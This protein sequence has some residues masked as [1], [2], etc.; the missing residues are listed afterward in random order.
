[1]Q[2]MKLIVGSAQISDDD[3]SKRIHAYLNELRA[4]YLRNVQLDLRNVQ[5]DLRNV[6]LDLRN[7]KVGS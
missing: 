3:R 6:Q 4:L 7:V 5:L 1:M 2:N